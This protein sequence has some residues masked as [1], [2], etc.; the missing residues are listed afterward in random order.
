MSSMEYLN[1]IHKSGKKLFTT[2]DLSLILG[3]QKSRTLENIIK[4][5]LTTE[6]FL[7]LERGKYCL[8][9]SQISDFEIANFL[10]SPSYISL[11]TA[12]NYHGIL[13]QFPLEI[14]SVT[15]AKRTTKIVLGK[16]YTY[17]KINMGLF[18]GYYKEENFLIATPEKALF[19]FL[20][21]ISR[22]LRTAS[23]LDE[24]DFSG[25][26]MDGVRR[27][28]ELVGQRDATRIDKLLTL[29]K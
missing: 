20:Y 23:Y 16:A 1:K 5:L 6:I 25:V 10:Y 13:S 29:C 21:L 22:S 14:T 17:S 19:D 24:M 12:L 11:E 9:S 8:A 28:L 18:T 26:K 3:V 7:S 2:T 27:Y 4:T 15:T